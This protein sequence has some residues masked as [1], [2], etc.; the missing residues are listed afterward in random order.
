MLRTTLKGTGDASRPRTLT[1]PPPTTPFSTKPRVTPPVS[2]VD[3]S[4]TT[5]YLSEEDLLPSDAANPPA[6]PASTRSTGTH[7]IP[8]PTPTPPPGKPPGVKKT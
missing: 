4:N 5:Q 6:P 8:P 2:T 3:K 1:P 7:K